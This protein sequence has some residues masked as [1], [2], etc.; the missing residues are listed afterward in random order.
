[1]G[2]PTHVKGLATATGLVGLVVL[3]ADVGLGGGWRDVA[4]LQWAAATLGIP[5]PPGSPAYLEA[6]RLVTLLPFG[7]LAWR[8]NISSALG[9]ASALGVTY[10]LAWL[11]IERAAPAARFGWR[12]AATS[13]RVPDG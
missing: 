2:T 4:E 3:L 6:A 7:S 12:A 8:V 13:A 5:H 1:M 11:A 9:G 10:W